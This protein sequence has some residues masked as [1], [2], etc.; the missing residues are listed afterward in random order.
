MEIEMNSRIYPHVNIGKDSEIADFSI[1]GKPPVGKTDGELGLVIGQGAI[2]RE[3][4]VIYAGSVIGDF[5][6]TGHYAVI[7]EDNIIG[8][9]CSIGTSS[10]L[11]PGNRLGNNV[12]IH[13]GCFLERVTLEDG[14]FVGPNT[15]FLDDIHPRCPQ[16][17]ACGR[18]AYVEENVSIGGNVTI[19]PYV[20]IG[21]NSLI[22]AGTVVT[23]DVPPDS[24]VTAIEIR[25]IKSISDIKCFKELYI[26]PYQWRK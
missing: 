15:V 25:R 21:K 5:L 7:R 13:S 24:V 16:F 3:F 2:I 22:G 9:H 12:R 20:R 17:D 14:V 8:N 18:G 19:L 6:S 11:G 4:C 26:T 1:I 10:E 23:K